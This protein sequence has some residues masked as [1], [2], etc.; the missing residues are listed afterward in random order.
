[1]NMVV[2]TDTVVRGL[3][4]PEGCRWHDGQLWFS[5]MHTGRVHSMAEGASQP[6]VEFEIDD[7]PSGIGW[8]ADGSMV[9]SAMLTRKL[10]RWSPEGGL[11]VYADLTQHTEHPIN[12]LVTD[13]RGNVY[14]GG[15]GYDLYGG[16]EQQPGQIFGVAPDRSVRLLANDLIFPNGMV[17][18]ESGELVVAETWGARLTAFDLTDDAQL[19][20]QRVWAELP[21]GNDSSGGIWVSSIATH[22]FLRVTEGGTVT[23]TLNLEDRLAVDCVLGGAD[24]A[25]L[26]LATSN[27]WQPEETEP[28]QSGQMESVRVNVNG[29]L[30]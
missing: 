5:D 7:Q 30:R 13:A 2:Q 1:M 15:F 17:I 8:L 21:A 20:N 22:T 26:F 10:Y 6:T 27:S 4:F 25:T 12:D 16:G 3:R 14:V 29:N 18:L 11:E 9:I 24:G 28:A 19:Q 23:D